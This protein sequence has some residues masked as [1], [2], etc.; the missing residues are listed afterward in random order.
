MDGCNVSGLCVRIRSQLFDAIPCVTAKLQ[1]L[2]YDGH[3]AVILAK[4]IFAGD[5]G[6]GKRCRTVSGVLNS[7]GHGADCGAGIVLDVAGCD[8][9]VRCRDGLNRGNSAVTRGL[10]CSLGCCSV[11]GLTAGLQRS[12]Q[13]SNA[14]CIVL[15]LIAGVERG[16]DNGNGRIFQLGDRL[17]V[18]RFKHLLVFRLGDHLE[19]NDECIIR[20]ERLRNF[21]LDKIITGIRC[22]MLIGQ[23][24]CSCP[25]PCCSVVR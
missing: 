20:L 1:R 24:L 14:V 17:I 2:E 21:E 12:F 5:D 23:R 13:G 11:D 10:D 4:L 6:A 19:L 15:A 3:H 8:L 16:F 7:N 18:E 25:I 22:A 9:L